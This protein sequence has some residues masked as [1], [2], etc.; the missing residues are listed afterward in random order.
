[1]RATQ[2]VGLIEKTTRSRV[3][4]ATLPVLLPVRR[5]FVFILKTP[6]NVVVLDFVAPNLVVPNQAAPEYTDTQCQ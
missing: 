5:M 2:I 1:M 3:N 4:F 6:E